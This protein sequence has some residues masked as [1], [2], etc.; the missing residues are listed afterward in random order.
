MFLIISPEDV[1]VYQCYTNLIKKDITFIHELIAFASLD[2]ID[3][4]EL[5]NSSM[6]IKLVD[7]FNESQ[8]SAFVTAG[9]MR[10]ILL[11]EG[12]NEDSIK[13]FFQEAYEYYCK[14]LLNP[15]IDK[16]SKIFSDNFNV[17]IKQAIKKNLN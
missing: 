7:K 14:V 11:H 9:K 3:L 16:Q 2:L 10:F 12:K 13:L 6:Y 4:S 8:V 5:N 17:K 1:V 15:F